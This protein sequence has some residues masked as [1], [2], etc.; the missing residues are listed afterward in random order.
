MP[1]AARI[2]TI[3]TIIVET[4]TTV[5]ASQIVHELSVDQLKRE[6]RLTER[7]VSFEKGKRNYDLTHYISQ[8]STVWKAGDKDVHDLLHCDIFDSVKVIA[9]NRNRIA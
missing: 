3:E 1:K 6:E 8:D 4:G 5:S 9:Y 7:Y 2:T